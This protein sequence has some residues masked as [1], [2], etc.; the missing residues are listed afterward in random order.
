MFKEK[1]ENKTQKSFTMHISDKGLVFFIIYIYKII[2]IFIYT[3]IKLVL[4][5]NK[6]TTQSKKFWQNICVKT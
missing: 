4:H 6:K 2:Y 1:K 3:Y 5:H